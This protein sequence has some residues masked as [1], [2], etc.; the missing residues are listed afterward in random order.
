M[1]E[2]SSGSRAH[3]AAEA[4]APERA[5]VAVADGRASRK[6]RPR[7][8]DGAEHGAEPRQEPNVQPE[9]ERRRRTWRPPRSICD[10]VRRGPKLSA[11]LRWRVPAAPWRGQGA[12]Q[13]HGWRRRAGDCGSCSRWACS[14]GC[15]EADWRSRWRARRSRRG[16]RRRLCKRSLRSGRPNRPGRHGLSVRHLPSAAAGH[17]LVLAEDPD[18]VRGQPGAVAGDPRR[19]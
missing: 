15:G 12:W 18:G 19:G 11:G 3:R 13:V 16:W 4:H 7:W 8:I 10:R 1:T 9:G 2:R 14:N 5:V 17:R 6:R